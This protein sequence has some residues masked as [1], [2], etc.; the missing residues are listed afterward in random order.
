MFG[1]FFVILISRGLFDYFLYSS[2]SCCDSKVGF[3]YFIVWRSVLIKPWAGLSSNSWD[4]RILE[5]KIWSGKGSND[6]EKY[7]HRPLWF[8]WFYHWY[9][10]QFVSNYWHVLKTKLKTNVSRLG[11]WLSNRSVWVFKLEPIRANQSLPI[12]MNKW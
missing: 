1:I 12:T 5:R 11:I 3:V 4:S 7:T 9:I 10:H 2:S 8:G 6:R